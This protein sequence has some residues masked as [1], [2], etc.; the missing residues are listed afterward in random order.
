MAQE[1]MQKCA[2]CKKD[3]PVS[4]RKGAKNGRWLCSPCFYKNHGHALSENDVQPEDPNKN[5][6]PGA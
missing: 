1:P 6:I 4:T 2:D 3:V 5:V